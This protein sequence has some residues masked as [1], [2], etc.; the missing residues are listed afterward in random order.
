MNKSYILRKNS[1]KSILKRLFTTIIWK[2][3]KKISD[4]R[5][6]QNEKY[7]YLIVSEGVVEDF[8][9]RVERIE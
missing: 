6:E 9:R 1:C 5:K 3:E 8:A 4:K 2:Y 7:N